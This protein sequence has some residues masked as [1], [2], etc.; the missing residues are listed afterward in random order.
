IIHQHTLTID[1]YQENTIDKAFKDGHFY[2][3]GLP[4]PSVFGIPAYLVFEG[5]YKLM[6]NRW[7][8]PLSS[9]QSYK[10]D[11]AGGFYQQDNVEF[12]LSTIW[13]TWFTLSLFSALS[14]VVIFHLFSKLGLPSYISMIAAI[15]YSFGTPVF[16]FST[17]YFSHVFNASMI[18]L[19]LYL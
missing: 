9:I 13:I 14:T 16:F 18:I 1:A 8:A 7:L 5:L 12:F 15:I 11:A 4:G 19:V 2:S 10:Q 3:A 17:T 6:P